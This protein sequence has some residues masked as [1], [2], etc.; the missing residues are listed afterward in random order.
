MIIKDLETDMKDS[1]YA[2]KTAMDDY[3][4][5]MSE[6]QATRMQDE[7]SITDKSAAKAELEGKLVDTKD[8]YASS[9]DELSIIQT[10]IQDLHASCDFIVQNYDL[11]KEARGNEV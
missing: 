5:L 9:K 7:K 1:E 2:E 11:R 6:S 10:T 4:K 3:G 8:S